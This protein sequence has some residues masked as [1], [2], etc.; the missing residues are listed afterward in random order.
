MV[1]MLALLPRASSDSLSDVHSLGKGMFMGRHTAARAFRSAVLLMSVTLATISG[2]V[3]PVPLAMAGAATTTVPSSPVGTQL[4]WL[5]SIRQLPLST[6]VVTMHF[7]PMFLTE[8]SPAQLNAGLASLGGGTPQLLGLSDVAATSL[9]AVVAFGAGRWNVSLSVDAAGLIASLVFSPGDVVPSSWAEVDSQLHSVA[10]VTGFLAAKVNANGTC[11]SVHA[12]KPT[13]ARPL[14]SL[15][16]LYILGALANAVRQH[17]ISWNQKVT[18]TA[19]IKT[20]GAGTLQNVPDGTQMTVRQVAITTISES[21]NTGADLLL[22]L[23]GRAAVQAQVRKWVAKSSLDI[24]F[25]TAKELFALHYSNFPN[26]AEH[27]LS[28]S[29]ARRASYLT[30]TIDAV[31]ASS[32][33]AVS[34]PRD[35]DTIEWFASPNDLCRTFSGLASLETAPNLG[36][37]NTILSTNSGGIDL[38]PTTWPRIWFKGGS[39]PGVL[40]LGYLARDNKGQ[41]YVVIALTENPAT[42]LSQQSTLQLLAVVQ[43]AFGLLHR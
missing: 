32:E 8:A 3:V 19:A 35:I 29:P 37:L 16:K 13:T 5:L 9:H 23:V 7:D 28:L 10:P 31:S 27:Y 42:A 30:S 17:K 11:T 18:I 39:E 40:T 38:S 36:P 41:T 4:A 14:G 22:Q 33:V 2:L 34:S 43:G 6:A 12:V 1:A 15:F 24:P 21:D 25:L 26:L 20:S